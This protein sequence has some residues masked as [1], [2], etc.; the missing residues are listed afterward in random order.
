MNYDHM[1]NNI[2]KGARKKL[3]KTKEGKDQSKETWW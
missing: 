1:A 2:R 3:G